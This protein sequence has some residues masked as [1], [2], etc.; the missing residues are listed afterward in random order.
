MRSV[1]LLV[2]PPQS[3]VVGVLDQ[4]H[5]L[6]LISHCVVVDAETLEAGDQLGR[7]LGEVESWRPVRDILASS[8]AIAGLRLV[9]VSGPITGADLDP[10]DLVRF[11]KV[12]QLAQPGRGQRVK[13][14]MVHA[15][16][17]ALPQ[18]SLYEED[19]PYAR[20]LNVVIAPENRRWRSHAHSTTLDDE[21]LA[22]HVGLGLAGILGLW[23]GAAVSPV[24][25]LDDGPQVHVARSMSRAIIRDGIVEDVAA[26]ARVAEEL[27]VPGG[28][29]AA[30][31]EEMADLVEERRADLIDL[32][33]L[34]P[35]QQPSLI[36]REIGWWDA[37][38]LAISR[39]G[40]ILV[41][42]VVRR[43]ERMVDQARARIS[44]LLERAIF[45]FPE[46]AS[47][48]IR[49]TLGSHGLRE[50]VEVERGDVPAQEVLER[51]VEAIHSSEPPPYNAS[52]DAREVAR[53]VL[54]LAD[55]GAPA[56][57]GG[58][59]RS[60][61]VTDPYRLAR[62]PLRWLDPVRKEDVHETAREAWLAAAAV[63]LRPII[64]RDAGLEVPERLPIVVDIPEGAYGRLGWTAIGECRVAS[65]GRDV[66]ALVVLHPLPG[67]TE[68]ELLATL[69]HEMIHA[70]VPEA[71]HGP[72]FEN[73]C[74]ALG[75]GGPPEATTPGDEF[76]VRIEPVLEALGSAPDEPSP[77]FEAVHLSVAEAALARWKNAMER[78]SRFG[79]E[80]PESLVSRDGSEPSASPGMWARLRQRIRKAARPLLWLL[81]LVV[82]LLLPIAVPLLLPTVLP[83]VLPVLVIVVP[84]AALRSVRQLIKLGRR[85]FSERFLPSEFDRLEADV[86]A[87]HDAVLDTARLQK[88]ASA[89]DAA[90]RSMGFVCH[91]PFGLSAEGSPVPAAAE[92]DF[93][94]P[95]AFEIE[96]GEYRPSEGAIGVVRSMRP[97]VFGSGWLNSL[98]ES[99][100]A[101][102]VVSVRADDPEAP[103]PEL[104]SDEQGL[105]Y[106]TSPEALAHLDRSVLERFR[107]ALG[108][109]T[110]DIIG[111]DGVRAH[112]WLREAGEAVRAEPD[113]SLW[114][115]GRPDDAPASWLFARD[116]VIEGGVSLAFDPVLLGFPFVDLVARTDVWGRY[117]PSSL[118]VFSESKAPADTPVEG[119]A[120]DGPDR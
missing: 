35:P 78:A 67:A 118:S 41:R 39:I 91:H 113:A 87:F 104:V 106:L 96:Q 120:S 76:V 27:P 38:R 98:V 17:S 68:V 114:R 23:S 36:R 25:E 66:S 24:D 82:A 9:A 61:V 53:R 83:F 81:V 8:D 58:D 69:V 46:D 3:A 12:L 101:S 55:T 30:S 42:I 47:S 62:D 54:A 44:S 86:G 115:M 31:D 102:Y 21:H 65:R 103:D 85:E 32:L 79:A 33:A 48:P 80:D 43:F 15:P 97:R 1:N 19:E 100:G 5:E 14:V 84:L 75:L 72:A 4:L 52:R 13:T 22:A 88:L 10:S 117:E 49:I 2:L 95:L 111:V 99:L 112:T 11:E 119:R 93:V 74:D 108:D 92:P 6:R 64:A 16:S 56:A 77:L 70:A 26:T 28:C 51:L 90:S 37:I 40:P 34:T 60:P 59:P 57:P 73:A 89:L 18:L 107:E 20:M 109:A 110:E 63:L 116:T 71:G 105:R 94:R 7:W 50:I 29:R 45:D